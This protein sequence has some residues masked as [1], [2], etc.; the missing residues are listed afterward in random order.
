MDYDSYGLETCPK[1]KVE[2][3]KL[4]GSREEISHITPQFDVGQRRIT[5]ILIILK[6]PT[7]VWYWY[8]YNM[9][10]L[11]QYYTRVSI[12]MPCMHACHISC[13]MTPP[14]MRHFA[15]GMDR[16]EST[17]S[18]PK[19]CSWRNRLGTYITNACRVP[20]Q[21]NALMPNR[22]IVPMLCLIFTFKVQLL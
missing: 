11:Y 7:S 18:T 10:W 8:K 22:I 16:S 12:D 9:V 6:K 3:W 15:M 4:D 5:E 2:R 20:H 13:G 19:K 21:L 1:M 14:G 17:V